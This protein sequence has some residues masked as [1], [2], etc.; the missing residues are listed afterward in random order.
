MEARLLGVAQDGGFPQP[1]CRCS[2]CRNL[3]IFRSPAACL[4]IVDESNQRYWIIDTPPQFGEAIQPLAGL[5]LAGI[6]LTHGHVGHYTGLMFLGKEAMAT[7][8]LPVWCSRQMR[9]LLESNEPWASLISGTHIAVQ[10]IATL[11]TYRIAPGL[12]IAPVAVPHRGEFTDTFAYC[13]IG[14]KQ[15]LFY[16]PDIDFWPIDN[17]SLH[18]LLHLNEHLLLDATFFSPD[19]LPGRDLKQI[20]HPFVTDAIDHLGPYAEKVTFIH[21]NH[22]NPILD[23][24]S[25]A[26]KIVRE[27]GFQV[28]SV[29]QRFALA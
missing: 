16:C 27:A 14:P 25:S 12:Q 26:S 17:P 29:G 20:P 4:A 5:E 8:E 22:S 18:T 11:E 23:P 3:G 24:G 21:M 28:G 10:E 15:S 1:G 7:R 13:V 2:N 6:F 9:R 19:E